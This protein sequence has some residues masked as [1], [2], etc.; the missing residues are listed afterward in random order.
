[1]LN[2]SR[3]VSSPIVSASTTFSNIAVRRCFSLG[4]GATTRA[5]SRLSTVNARAMAERQLIS[6][7]PM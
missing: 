4:F 3:F 7:A 6:V 2:N 5:Y 1:M